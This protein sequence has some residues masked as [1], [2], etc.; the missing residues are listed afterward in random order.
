VRVS[1][2]GHEP[3]WFPD[4]N[5]RHR[6]RYWDGR[7]WTVWV[8]DESDHFDE[9]GSAVILRRRRAWTSSLM[10]FRVFID[11][12]LAGRIANGETR[13][14][15]VPPGAHRVRVKQGYLAS[16]ELDVSVPPDGQLR[17]GPRG[18]GIVYLGI[19]L[20][21]PRRSLALEGDDERDRPSLLVAAVG[22]LVWI[23]LYMAIFTLVRFA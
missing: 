21:Q 1:N 17:C 8:A 4:P 18:G 19:S 9:T 23:A 16:R 11:G 15:S 22:V 12:Q 20:V 5:G 14:F 3:A 2:P 7:E 10:R 6:L 13:T